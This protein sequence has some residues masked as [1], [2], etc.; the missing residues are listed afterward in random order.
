MISWFRLS[1]CWAPYLFCNEEEG[2]SSS[3][4]IDKFYLVLLGS[5]D[6][7]LI[8]LVCTGYF[9]ILTP[10]PRPAAGCHICFSTKKKYLRLQHNGISHLSNDDK[11]CSSNQQTRMAG[12][13]QWF[14]LKSH[15]F[16]VK[17]YS[18]RRFDSKMSKQVQKGLAKILRTLRDTKLWHKR[19]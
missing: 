13:T 5:L 8:L 9:V 17:P 19:R 6:N 12:L 15:V 3:K 14:F 4:Q 16:S 11:T 10:W 7:Y 18:Y 2:P 1:C